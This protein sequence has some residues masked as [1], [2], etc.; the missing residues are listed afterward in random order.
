M[1]IAPLNYPIKNSVA[2]VP[3]VTGSDPVDS[4][5]GCRTVSFHAASAVRCGEAA[6]FR[7]AAVH[8]SRSSTAIPAA[9][10]ETAGAKLET[11][12]AVPHTRPRQ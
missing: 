7:L 6:R 11:T 9:R 1:L 2:S 4:N 8:T 10:F 12:T 3:G 5:E